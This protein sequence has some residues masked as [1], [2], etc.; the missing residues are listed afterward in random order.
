MPADSAAGQPRVPR[1]SGE[2]PGPWLAI[3]RLCSAVAAVL[4]ALLC[5]AAGLL[6]GSGAAASALAGGVLVVV[7][8]GVSLLIGHWVGRR[9][10]SAALGAF[11]AGYAVKVVLLG[12]LAFAF[13][14]PAWLDGTWFLI[15]VVSTVV[16]WQA[17]ELYA[18]SKLRFHL[19]GSGPESPAPA[20]G[21]GH[22]N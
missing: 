3:L 13:G 4:V 6:V 19:Y 17:A 5:G 16:L 15:A 10:P 21:G 22:G 14:A 11:M 12:V 1:A 2:T 20:P 9:N 18:F 7:F 8:F